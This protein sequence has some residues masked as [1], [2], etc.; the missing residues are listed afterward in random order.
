MCVNFL[1]I[2]VPLGRQRVGG[3][4]SAVGALELGVVR[5][6]CSDLKEAMV[7]VEVWVLVAR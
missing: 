6:C 4:E 7:M 5:P 1:G 2:R 3:D